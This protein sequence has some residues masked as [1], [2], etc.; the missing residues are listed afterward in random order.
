[1]RKA[2]VQPRGQPA[3]ESPGAER[4]TNRPPNNSAD[5]RRYFFKAGPPG[6]GRR[7]R[8]RV[9][10]RGNRSGTKVPLA[11]ATSVARS[12]PPPPSPPPRPPARP[13]TPSRG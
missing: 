3:L 1:M 5:P 6:S 11:P 9:L 10:P 12:H 7:R 8:A 2:V 4:R 13:R